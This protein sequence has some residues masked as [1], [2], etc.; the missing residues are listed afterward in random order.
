VREILVQRRVPP[1]G[2]PSAASLREWATA[3]LGS[4]AGDLSI[5]I[6]GEDESQDL[7]RRYRGK[8]KPTNVLSFPYDGEGLDVPVLG[9]LVICAAVVAREAQEQGKDPRAHCAHIVVH[10]CLQIGR[11]HV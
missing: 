10:G 6:V 1:Q 2:V 7:N 8:D 11:A 5:R 9:D 3:A 4:A